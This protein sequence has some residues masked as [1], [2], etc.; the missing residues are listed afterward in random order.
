MSFRKFAE[1]FRRLPK[2]IQ[3]TATA[4]GCFPELEDKTLS[5]KTHTCHKQGLEELSWI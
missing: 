5:L 1:E 2:T 3:V 4:L